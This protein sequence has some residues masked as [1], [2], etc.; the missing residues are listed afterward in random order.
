MYNDY[1]MSTDA[2]MLISRNGHFYV[3]KPFDDHGLY[4]HHSLMMLTNL[5]QP[6]FSQEKKLHWVEMCESCHIKF[7]FWFPIFG[8]YVPF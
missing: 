2:E 6:I 5:T 7:Y 8:F 1:D 4:I 3:F